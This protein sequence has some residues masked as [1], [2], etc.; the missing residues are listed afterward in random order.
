L[1]HMCFGHQ[2][3]NIC[4]RNLP[5]GIERHPIEFAPVTA[6]RS[7]EEY[8]MEAASIPLDYPTLMRVGGCHGDEPEFGY[9]D[10]STFSFI[11]IALR[12]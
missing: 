8:L 12:N 2:H 1:T 9:T 3:Q 7:K 11:R 4:C 6:Q 5:D 10:F